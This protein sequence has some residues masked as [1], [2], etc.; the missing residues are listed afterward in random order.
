MGAAL[1]AGMHRGFVSMA[2]QFHTLTRLSQ[3][4]A[5]SFILSLKNRVSQHSLGFFWKWQWNMELSGMCV[6]R[7][8][9]SKIITQKER[10]KFTGF[11]ACSC[12]YEQIMDVLKKLTRHC[13]EHDKW[14]LC[15]LCVCMYLSGWFSVMGEGNTEPLLCRSL[16]KPVSGLGLLT[17]LFRS[18][19][20]E[21][22]E[23]TF[24]CWPSLFM[25]L[26][27]LIVRK[28]DLVVSHLNIYF[29]VKSKAWDVFL[30]SICTAPAQQD[31][32]WLRSL[33]SI[34]VQKASKIDSYLG[35]AKFLHLT[36]AKKQS[37]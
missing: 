36:N 32:L 15:L 30:F 22:H 3:L 13:W 31:C 8:N 19:S 20:G 1:S 17:H 2:L 11:C 14:N 27:V 26:R 33:I 29:K 16:P 21:L 34:S 18:S 35:Q 7:N 4:S 12:F 37:S 23:R 28:K 6:S 24:F 5:S 25:L 10:L 9:N